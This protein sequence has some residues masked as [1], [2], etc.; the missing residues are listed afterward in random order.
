MVTGYP[1]GK[2][3]NNA[4]WPSLAY[5]AWGGA[6]DSIL[7]TDAATA[8][9]QVAFKS[10]TSFRG[11]VLSNVDSL[12]LISAANWNISNTSICLNKGDN[13]FIPVG[14]ITDF[15][16]LSRTQGSAVD[17][18]A[19]EIPY[20]NTTVTFNSDG[21][22][23]GYTTGQVASSAAGTPLA[24]TITANSLYKITSVLYNGVEVKGEMVG[25]I[26]TA[27]ALTANA[28]LV[29][30][31][32][33]ATA[34]VKTQN[35]FQCISAGQNIELKGLTVGD[36]VV[37]YNMTGSKIKSEKSYSSNV[38]ISLAK[39]IYLVKVANEVRKVVVR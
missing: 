9:S 6:T 37:I 25:D 36:E 12:N 33:L 24:F 20:Y 1:T 38:S 17:L 14:I 11:R 7:T 18:G 30:Q 31:F 3:K 21:T 23:T 35:D 29:V 4:V 2:V 32:D 5:Q 13:S 22:I 19:Y 28:T 27:P 39:G 8:Y 16:A 10:P 26:Y 34:L 15:V